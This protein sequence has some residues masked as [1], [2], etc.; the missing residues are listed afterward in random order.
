MTA[1]T[2]LDQPRPVRDDGEDL[3]LLLDVVSTLDRLGIGEHPTVAPIRSAAKHA[4]HLTSF[5]GRAHVEA[6]T[7]AADLGMKLR[8]GEI[9]PEEV[10]DQIGATTTRAQAATAASDVIRHAASGALFDAWDVL[11]HRAQDLLDDVVRP[12]V[13]RV[14]EAATQ[15]AATI[16]EV[17]VDGESATRQ[18]ATVINAWNGA[19]D[20]AERW[21]DLHELAELLR[22]RGLLTDSP[23]G[24]TYVPL[25]H[26]YAD[27]HALVAAGVTRAIRH[28]SLLLLD[29]VRS[30]AKP[31]LLTTAQ[32]AEHAHKA[33]ADRAARL[34]QVEAAADG[35][36]RDRMAARQAE[37]DRRRGVRTPDPSTAA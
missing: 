4:E 15:A 33:H 26:R 3:Y 10:A 37:F 21:T 14:V 25:A 6:A 19:R 35:A 1:Y 18:T 12:E 11:R 20:L 28:P 5:V 7:I 27:P 13:D 8:R 30:G 36:F 23:S 32:A 22:S 2:Q 34:N 9:T 17:V 24:T 31:G 29:A 16:P